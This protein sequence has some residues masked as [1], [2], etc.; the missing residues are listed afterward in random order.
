VITGNVSAAREAIIRI[1]VR[2]SETREESIDAIIDTGFDG[3]L[4]LPA[5]V[6]SDLALPFAGATRA[7]LGDG[8]EVSLDAFEAIVIW[9]SGERSVV[10]LA[11]DGEPLVGM[12]LLSGHRVVL[13]VVEGGRVEIQAI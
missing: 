2:G 1:A 7:K 3:F 10:T 13:D 11:T 6:V 9:D 4:T 5:S 8:R 12:A